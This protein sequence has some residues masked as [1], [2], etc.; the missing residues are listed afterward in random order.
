M[1]WLLLLPSAFAGFLGTWQVN[2][3]RSKL[4]Q[5]VARDTAFEVSLTSHT[6]ALPL[7]L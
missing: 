7:L 5:M 1:G 2:R 4:E 6:P 3:R